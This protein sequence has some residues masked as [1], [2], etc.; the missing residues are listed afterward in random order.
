MIRMNPKTQR[1]ITASGGSVIV[2]PFVFPGLIRS[3]RILVDHEV[4]FA[5][6]VDPSSYQVF[7]HEG[8]TVY[9]HT[10]LRV[11][12]E[13]RLSF[14]GQ[15]PFEQLEVRGVRRLMAENVW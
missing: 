13:L 1:R 9:V 3:R 10:S 11:K 14:S 5:E 12:K 2:D 4:Y 15:R 7:E 8:V 6:P